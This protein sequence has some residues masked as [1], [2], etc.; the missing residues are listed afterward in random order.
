MVSSTKSKRFL[1]YN[2]EFSLLL[3]HL[4][5]QMHNRV[6]TSLWFILIFTKFVFLIKEILESFVS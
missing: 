4:Q 5:I 1:N 2:T 6:Q 3:K